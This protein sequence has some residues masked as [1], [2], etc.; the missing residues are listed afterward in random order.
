MPRVSLKPDN[1]DEVN[2][3]F[4]HRPLASPVFLN[5]V[6]KCGTHLMKNIL[7][8]FVANEQQY[9]EVFIQYPILR[10]HAAAAFAPQN[11]RLSWGHMLYGDEPAL[12]LRK[13]RHILL[14]RDPYDWVLARARFFLS[15]SFEASLEHLK[16]GHI[17]TEEVLN[18]MIFGIHSKVPTL[19]EIFENNAAAWLGTRVH[20]YRYEELVAAVKSLDSDSSRVFFERLLT[21]CGLDALPDDWQKRVELG[22]DRKQSGTARENLGGDQ[23]E[24]PAELPDQQKALVDF[25][26]PGLRAL[27][28]YEK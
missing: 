25:A 21:D 20:L 10:Q 7:R 1:L 8:M 16:G 2:K 11:P 26:A 9:H 17:S 5:S 22:A 27:L 14:V 24:L 4:D 18:M 3:Q 6:P 28:G 13:T 15:D 23:V 12:A 19:R